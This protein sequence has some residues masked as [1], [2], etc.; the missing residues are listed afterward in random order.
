MYI[1]RRR[2]RGGEKENDEMK[3]GRYEVIHY[4]EE[5]C[6][7]CF[8]HFLIKAKANGKSSNDLN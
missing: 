6:D 5:C 8:F 3:S 7:H 1:R 4:W 2:E